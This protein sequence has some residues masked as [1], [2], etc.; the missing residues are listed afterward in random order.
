[1]NV[2][3]IHGL[4]RTPASMWG[5]AHFLRSHHYQPHFFAYWAWRETYEEIVVRL[6]SQCQHLSQS[7]DYAIIAHSL[8][9]VLSRSALHDLAAL[10][11]LVMLGPPNQPPRLAQL[12]RRIPAFDW[13]TADCGRKLSQAQ[14]YGTLP[15]PEGQYTIIAGSAGP[16][17]GLSPFGS[18]SN[19]GIVAVNETWIHECDR[20]I[21]LPVFHTFMMNNRSVQQKIIENL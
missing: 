15:K 19:D 14:F 4:G 13:V 17:G 21:V 6:R 18:D 1:M 20:P 11:H 3:L 10:P 5:L 16:T 9:G 7:G 2:L 12:A 8:G